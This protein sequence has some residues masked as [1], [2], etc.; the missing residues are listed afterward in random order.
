MSFQRLFYCFHETIHKN[1]FKYNKSATPIP[2]PTSVEE[3]CAHLDTMK[4]NAA[5]NDKNRED[6]VDIN[7]QHNA[8]LQ[9]LVG[10]VG[11]GEHD[12]T[13]LHTE[14]VEVNTGNAM[15]YQ[16]VFLYMG[17]SFDLR[18]LLITRFS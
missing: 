9:D 12:K 10:R 8:V 14:R 7:A 13:H 15:I 5:G 3:A 4:T 1:K 2:T 11:A 18:V 16:C 17:I 6:E